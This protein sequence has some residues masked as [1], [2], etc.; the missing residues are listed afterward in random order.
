M[1]HAQCAR[2]HLGIYLCSHKN[3]LPSSQLS[4]LCSDKRGQ[5][6]CTL[7]FLD[8]GCR[9]MQGEGP[10]PAQGP[11]RVLGRLRHRLLPCQVGAPYGRPSLLLTWWQCAHLCW[12]HSDDDGVPQMQHYHLGQESNAK[13]YSECPAQKLLSVLKMGRGEGMLGFQ[14][15]YH[16]EGITPCPNKVPWKEELPQSLLRR[17]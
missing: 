11:G 7:H 14:I 10:P 2:C 3:T 16:G 1:G 6:S 12:H 4:L 17:L 15:I 5:D 13:K 9:S 8:E